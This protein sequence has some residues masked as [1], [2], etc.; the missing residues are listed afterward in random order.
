MSSPD[1]DFFLPLKGHENSSR[2][3]AKFEHYFDSE[4]DGD[5][6][7]S[8]FEKESIGKVS[9]W[10]PSSEGK[11]LQSPSK[12]KTRRKCVVASGGRVKYSPKI[13]KRVKEQI[14]NSEPGK[15]QSQETKRNGKTKS[16]MLTPSTAKKSRLEIHE[17]SSEDEDKWNQTVVKKD[18]RSSAKTS[19]MF[20]IEKQSPRTPV[21]IK[22]SA[23]DQLGDKIV[24]VWQEFS[25]AD[26]ERPKLPVPPTSTKLDF[27]LLEDEAQ[28]RVAVPASINQYL[29]DYQR[30][31][32]QFLFEHF[33]KG[34][35]AILGDD[36][37]L[38]KTVQVIGFLAALLGKSGKRTD[39]LHALPKFIKQDQLNQ[40]EWE[41]VIVDEVHKI[42]GLRAQVTQ[43]LRIIKTPCR[44]GLTGTALQNN[45]TELW[46]LLDWAQPKVLGSL[47][48]FD[49]GFVK[50]IEIGQKHD[51]TKRE[52]AHARK[53]R[54]KFASIRKKMLLRRTKKLIADQL[55]DKEELVVMCRLTDLQVSVCKAI[56]NHPDMQL[57]LQA[58][59]P[60]DCLSGKQRASCC[61]KIL[62][63]LL[64]VFE[65]KH[66]KVLIFSYS[67]KLL[68]I[69]EH[70]VISQGHEYSRIDG[71]VSGQRRR[72]IVLQ[73]NTDPSLFICL[74]STKAG[75]LGLNLT[76]ANKVVIFDP[77]WNPS[78]DLQAQDRAYRIGQTRDV[79]VFRLVSAGTIEE[80]IYLRQIYKQQL[81]E[82]A[83]GN[84]NARRYFHGV[85]GDKSNQ[86]ELFGVKNMFALR[87]G[88]VCLT[89][90][91]LKRNERLEKGLE[92]YD[93]T[94]YVPP[95][96]D[97]TAQ[98]DVFEEDE[99]EG[100]VEGNYSEEEKAS[101]EEKEEDEDFLRDIFG[102]D[103]ISLKPSTSTEREITRSVA[104]EGQFSDSSDS[105]EELS[106]IPVKRQR[107]KTARSTPGKLTHN[108]KRE[109]TTSSKSH[110]DNEAD[111]GIIPTAGMD[112]LDTSASTAFDELFDM[113]DITFS[114]AK[115]SA[116]VAKDADQGKSGE[117]ESSDGAV[118][119]MPR[120]SK[121]TGLSWLFADSEDESDDEIGSKVQM[122]R[123]KKGSILNREETQYSASREKQGLASNGKQRTPLKK[124][125][126]VAAS[127]HLTRQKKT[128]V[129]SKSARMKATFSSESSFLDASDVLHTHANI[130]VLGT[131]RA[132]DH[133]TRC[134]I[135]DVYELHTNTQAP[136]LVCDPLSQPEEEEN[137]GTKQGKQKRGRK[138]KNSSSQE[139][140]EE[141]FDTRQSIKAGPY[142]LLIGQTPPAIA[143]RQ[144]SEL[145]RKKGMSEEEFA[146]FVI[147]TSLGCRLDMLKDFYT[148][149]HSHGAVVEAV[150][151]LYAETSNAVAKPE[152]GMVS[153]G[154]D[155]KEKNSD[156]KACETPQKRSHKH[157][158]TDTPASPLGEKW[159]RS[160]GKLSPGKTRT[161]QPCSTRMQ[162]PFFLEPSTFASD[163]Q[164]S[165]TAKSPIHC[166]AD[167]GAW[168]NS[169]IS[170]QGYQPVSP[171]PK[172]R[173][174]SRVNKVSPLKSQHR[175][176]LRHRDDHF[177]KRQ[178][179]SFQCE[180]QQM[181]TSFPSETLP[182]QPESS[183][184]GQN[185]QHCEDIPSLLHEMGHGDNDDRLANKEK[186]PSPSKRL[187]SNSDKPS[188]S[189]R[190]QS[191]DMVTYTSPKISLGVHG[192]NKKVS[193][194]S[195]SAKVSSTSARRR[196]PV[197]ILDDIFGDSSSSFKESQTG[198]C[199]NLVCEAEYK[200]QGKN[201]VERDK[202][203]EAKLKVGEAENSGAI[204]KVITPTEVESAEKKI[205]RVKNTS[206]NS[207]GKFTSNK[208]ITNSEHSTSSSQ[209][210]ST[211]SHGKEAV[212]V[213]SRIN[214]A[215]ASVFEAVANKEED[216]GSEIFAA[217][218]TSSTFCE[219][220]KTS[221]RDRSARTK[222][223]R[224]DRGKYNKPVKYS[225][226]KKVY[227]EKEDPDVEFDDLENWG[228]FSGKRSPPIE[229][230]SLFS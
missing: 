25:E 124:R 101:D 181:D 88:N 126:Q 6:N 156:E 28:P 178:I 29:R 138:G 222:Q 106:L 104:V 159:R 129:T 148:Q 16:P 188:T 72:D 204:A 120:S 123:G 213:K 116:N 171:Q 7:Q 92:G 187:K 155:K 191:Q 125:V 153:S 217:L 127:H 57:V 214:V 206:S 226:S 165:I 177:K 199:T 189:K 147:K 61:Y 78:H 34:T 23:T 136:A 198:D 11:W 130:G 134:A 219:D 40:I 193:P 167:E 132:E 65:K 201:I 183:T 131:S 133:M 229:S 121:Y 111:H 197:S 207:K 180:Y 27:V 37:G 216:N 164:E 97:P 41:A 154:S 67:T 95:I 227:Q 31:G 12:S 128:L 172:S 173:L 4:S 224:E 146:N 75:G 66:D 26:A 152:K 169:N 107:G 196:Q 59:D 203:D 32:I 89:T 215:G 13:R 10:K 8:N 36:M 195:L 90:D 45:M 14:Q 93:I 137:N 185:A 83:V 85:Q 60:C 182:D 30:E 230:E 73:F 205:V 20:Q 163:S 70:Y 190:E 118:E 35:G 50:A 63:G 160:K 39:S 71:K 58:E 100:T 94:K 143:R 162:T 91:I 3:A 24:S 149:K 108:G 225:S 5:H 52:L 18:N 228:K 144:F 202:H 62:Q 86:G 200:S 158:T 17:Y 110:P 114:T 96:K 157:L 139:P 49:N 19:A 170:S 44:F 122:D 161:V 220:I 179:A 56:L 102:L 22:N 212:D 210:K 223:N 142:K 15:L 9:E 33:M 174:L 2:L 1:S 115:V 46:S 99:E 117:T 119:E 77:N 192:D 98:H 87:T 194:K 211:T 53:Q 151:K 80:N 79:K 55:P 81:D 175:T 47:E 166:H 145:A 135:K 113:S 176:R 105:G 184:L 38:G 76:G 150:A 51:A 218:L 186:F 141:M 48:Q 221:R 54:D 21:P 68:D 140:K 74:I 82:V 208:L 103:R 84:V 43:A 69:I 168:L 209:L 109:K 112:A 64:R 42:K